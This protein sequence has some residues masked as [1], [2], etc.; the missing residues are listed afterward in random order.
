MAL[1]KN[2]AAAT[3]LS[4]GLCAALFAFNTGSAQ[5]DSSVNNATTSAARN[6]PVLRVGS[7]T[8]YPPFEFL[9]SKSGQYVG[10]DID[11]IE[12]VGRRL[13]RR[14]EIV[15]MGLDAIVPALL[16]QNVDIGVS[17]FTITK[18]RAE[19]V[20]FSDPYYDAGLTIMT[21]KELADKIRGEKDLEGRVLCAEIGSAGALYSKSIPN[22]TIRTFN[23]AADAFIEMDKKGCDA[24]LND[25]PVNE[26]F[27]AQKASQGMSL[28]ELPYV[29]SDDKYGIAVPKNNP[30]LLAQI[31][32]ILARMRKDGSYDK[33]YQKWFGKATS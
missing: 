12:E 33:I 29:L 13:N 21:R 18:E 24:M 31:N 25:R 22:V 7:L 6:L 10:F 2:A 17:A 9:D 19:R 30:E 8:A 27:L 32:A 5:T 16:T 28:T 3:A 23:T 11:L 14:I 15:S 1:L 26:Y 4:L 20:N